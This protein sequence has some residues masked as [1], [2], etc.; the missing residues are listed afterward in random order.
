MPVNYA[1]QYGRELA[2]AYPYLSYF[3]DIL[4][5]GEAQRFRP[6]TGKTVWI[7]SMTTTGSHAA[8]REQ[9]TGVFN[10]NFSVEWEPKV[11]EM[12][13]EW[14]TLVDPMDIDETNE[15]ATIANITRTYNELQK[16][17]E[18]DAY[19]ASKLASFAATFGGTDSSSLTSSTILDLWDTYLAYM[20]NARVNRDRVMCKMTPNTYK[21]LKEA[22]GLTRF[23]ETTAGIR[24]V[25]RNVARLDGV[26][27]AEVPSDMMKTA[28]NFDV[29]GGGF[30]VADGAGQI[31]LLLYD[32][33]AV[34]VPVVYDSAMISAPTAQ[35]KGKWLYYERHYYGAFALN[36][37]GAG[38]FAHLSSAP[39]LGTL[40]VTSVAGTASGAT[41]IGATGKGI[42]QNGHADDNLEMY[43]T[44][45]NNSAPSVT[46]G[47]AL[48]DGVTWTKIAGVPVTLT[49][50][51][52][53]KYV[54]VALVNKVTGKAV[55]AGSA[56]EVV[57]A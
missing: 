2:N 12:D 9:I 1:E 31:D 33:M 54:T 15:V 32:P 40:T 4:N 36:Q 52:A 21:L 49:S 30:A 38:F 37:R 8:N 42:G 46:Y 55:A 17:P 13:R 28:Y 7:P 45:G 3:G 35:S 18:Q 53:N 5:V 23:V 56:T 50:Q 26:R 39:S 29:E 44:S 27:V 24:D 11:L 16:I 51:T 14:E 43:I 47:S 25:D 48:P 57:G 19:I 22:T 20:T 41:I 10:R 34:A 6:H